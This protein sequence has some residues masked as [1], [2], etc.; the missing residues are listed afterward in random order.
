MGRR[1]SA[2]NPLLGSASS[3]ARTAASSKDRDGSA[4]K[5]AVTELLDVSDF[6]ALVPRPAHQFPFT[7]DGFQK[8]AVARLEVTRWMILTCWGGFE[9]TV[10]VPACRWRVMD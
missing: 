3:A 5:W 1:G 9:R 7:L 8:Q 6:D 2:G 4:V 10:L